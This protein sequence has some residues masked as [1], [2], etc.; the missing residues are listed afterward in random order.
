MAVFKS[1]TVIT[2]E[3]SETDLIAPITD[4]NHSCDKENY[5]HVPVL[6][7]VN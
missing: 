3:D 1:I 5:S 2:I 4:Y 6:F 7:E